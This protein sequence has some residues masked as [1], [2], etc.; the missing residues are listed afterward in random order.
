[1][2]RTV[3]SIGVLFVAML[4]A[5]GLVIGSAFAAALAFGATALIVPGT[6]THNILPPNAV[7]G[8]K[9]N[10]ADRY[11]NVSGPQCSST[12]GCDLQGIDY[13]ASF[14]PVGFIPN[15]CPGYSCDTWNKSV[16]EGVVNLD[17]A[18][19]AALAAPG[20]DPII[21]F[22]YSQGGA[23]VSR[24]MYAIPDSA[25]SRVSVVTIGNINNPLGL[26]SR[27]SFLPT[28][29]GLNISFNPQLPTDIGVKSTNYSFEYDPVGDAP[30]YW[31][32]PLAVANALAAFVYVHGYYLDPTSN[33]PDDSLP[34]GYDD[35][36]LAT[37]IDNAPHRIHN[38]ATFVLIPQQG[39][40]PLYLPV[41]D[42][43]KQLGLS[44]LVKPLVALVN[45]VTKLLV[46]LGYDRITN[47]GIARTLSILPFNPL[48]FNPVDFSVKFVAAIAQGIQDALAGGASLTPAKTPV[49][50]LAA[51]GTA[52]Q[53]VDPV[54][55]KK[56]TPV[57]LNSSTPGT[58]L[59]QVSGEKSSTD[60]DA[61]AKAK[62]AEEKTAADAK[63]AA[64][65]DAADKAAAEA[66]AAEEKAAADA[67][68][69][70]E[71]EATEKAAADAK[72]A[73][74]KAA[75]EKAAAD[76][77]K[78]DKETAAKEQDAAAKAAADKAKEAADN[79]KA[80]GAAGDGPTKG[81]DTGT[82]AA[83][84]Q[85]A[86]AGDTEKQAA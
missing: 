76:K 2:R 8:Y 71:K 37:A 82:T 21:I 18:L 33:S 75:E 52:P 86:G 56:V 63:A 59:P 24:E 80:A 35:G 17:T 4:G 67:K 85:D 50:T 57:A 54:D 40:L 49:T 32:N 1:M 69:A 72:A 64:E 7:T 43:G 48:T 42:I 16:G 30:Q 38:D 70:A 77:L 41:L 19:T 83:P 65:K 73:K 46:N 31:G 3:R 55:T 5:V 34:Y 81:T 78:A 44:G 6:G 26:W 14:F 23:V 58:D 20:T 13:P 68:A 29:P 84:A 25:K 9:E 74:E 51:R 12:D 39:A 53:T 79:A 15:W 36:T 10:A 28:I 11:I 47:P 27:L 61:D 22:G 60:Q 62:A 66:K 45:P